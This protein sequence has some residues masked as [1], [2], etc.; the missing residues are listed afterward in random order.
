MSEHSNNNGKFLNCY[1][2]YCHIFLILILAEQYQKLYH[3][4]SEVTST[5]IQDVESFFLMFNNLIVHLENYFCSQL[6]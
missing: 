4:V 3:E 6:G 5:F 1:V 2:M